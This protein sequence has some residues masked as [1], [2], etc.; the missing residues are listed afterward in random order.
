M[1]GRKMGGGSARKWV[2]GG[3]AVGAFIAVPIVMLV[4][5]AVVL[6]VSM[7]S[8]F[9][10]VGAKGT[11]NP[12]DTDNTLY[13]S[14]SFEQASG[15]DGLAGGVSSPGL[16][17][18]GGISNTA[19]EAI[20]TTI[21]IGKTMGVP[22]EGWIIAVMTMMQES[23]L[24]KYANS[25]K[26]ARNYNGFGAP[27]KEFWLNV[28]KLSLAYPHEAVG[29]DADS[30]GYYQQRPSAGWG[31]TA[32]SKARLDPDAAVARLMD[33]RWG[34]QAFFGGPGGPSNRGL[35]DIDGWQSMSKGRA[36]QKVQISAFPDAYDKHEKKATALVDQYSDAPAI[37]LLDP[38]GEGAGS[39]GEVVRV[40]LGE[41]GTGANYFGP[42]LG[43]AAAIIEAGSKWIGT[44][45]SWGGGGLDGPTRGIG[46]GMDTVGFDCSGLTQYAVYNGLGRV[47]EANIGGDSRTQWR[48]AP[49]VRNVGGYNPEFLQ[50]ADLLFWSNYNSPDSIYHVAI[51]VGNGMILESPR[52]GLTVR[53]APMHSTS[54]FFGFIRLPLDTTAVAGEES[55]GE[56]I[57]AGGSGGSGGWK[58]D[59]SAG[60]APVAPGGKPS[61]SSTGLIAGRALK[62]SGGIVVNKNGAVIENM[63]I[64]GTLRVNADNVTIRN[65]RITTNT[66]HCGIA[67]GDNKG[68]LLVEHADIR[69]GVNGRFGLAGICGTGDLAGRLGKK[70]GDNVTVRYSKITGLADGLKAVDYGLYE[71]NYIHVWRPSGSSAHTDGIQGSGRS[72]FTIRY[73]TIGGPKYVPGDNAAIFIQAYTG[74]RDNNLSGIRVY[75]NWLNSGGYTI[76]SE[77]GKKTNGGHFKD[78]Q[79]Y[80]NIFGRGYKY[81]VV[82]ND[83]G[84]IKGNFGRWADNNQIV[85]TGAIR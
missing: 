54:K 82:H 66:D 27:G 3:V 72:N 9:G 38:A 56:V 62:K 21:G 74:K 59:T 58:P 57:Q 60:T 5:V 23:N 36:A 85:P 10:A 43:Q 11:G 6:T 14:G 13:Q 84:A 4:V 75:K 26:N 16:T 25:G 77:D 1:R 46:R 68:G 34:A 67:L 78:V 80:D 32:T 15:V 53:L 48:T 70:H 71:R 33:T 17:Y 18:S 47:E 35:L 69:M 65:V 28:A 41:C 7:S 51:Y 63:D 20:Q 19:R 24:K 55:G 42:A 64:N 8:I 29:N 50:P 49:G 61:A 76:H 22:R 52:T 73:N 12:C 31:D 79:M 39:G 45:Y 40:D 30:V 44:D 81:G 2:I 37:P 83:R